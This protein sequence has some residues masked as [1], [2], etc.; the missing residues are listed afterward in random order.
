MTYYDRIRKVAQTKS[1]HNRIKLEKYGRS[2][3]F[4]T[5]DK[6]MIPAP[7]GFDWKPTFD[8]RGLWHGAGR[9]GRDYRRLLETHPPY[10]DKYSALAGA[11]MINASFC[12]G[13]TWD[14]DIDL[15]DLPEKHQLY[16]L[17]HG[18]GGQHHFCHDVGGIGFPLGWGGLLDKV[19]HYKEVYRDDPEKLEFLTGEEDILLGIQSWVRR[20]ADEAARLASLEDDP[21]LRANL[22]EIARINYN[23]VS[24]PPK[25]FHE[26]CQFLVYFLL[27]AVMF[28][29]SGA[30]GAIDAYL[31][32]YFDADIASGLLTEEKATYILASLLVKDNQY[33]EIGGCWPDGSDRTSRL[34]YLV[35]EASHWLKIP[36]AICVR[37]H[38]DIDPGLMELAVRYLFEDKHGSPSFIGDKA[39]NEG[40]VKNGYSMEVARTRAKV[41]CSWGCLPGTEYT[42]NDIVKINF[43]KVF[44][45]AWRDMMDDD[46]VEPSVDRLWEL[47]EYRVNDAVEAIADSID[48]Q[49]RHI[50]R[51]SPE[52]A[53]DFMCHGPIERGV[54]IASGG[55]D[56]YNMCVDG[57]GLAV[58][59]DSFGALRERVEKEHRCTFRELDEILKNN[60]EGH[61][62]LRLLF[63][64]TPRYGSGGSYA[65]ECAVRFIDIFVKAVKKGPTKD[66][67]N[68]IPGLFSWANTLPM[69]RVLGATPNG[70]KAG[71]PINHGANPLPG[72]K[73]SGELTAMALAVS[74]VQPMWGNTAPIQ[75]EID[76]ILGKD[77]GGVEK[78]V[79]FL[80]TYCCDLNGTLV[81]INILDKDTILDAHAHPE[82]HPDLVVRVTGF[83]AYFCNLSQDFRQLVVDR[84][85]RG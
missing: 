78:M 19:R 72:F 10:V 27:Q 81:N 52:M 80:M 70:R 40:F 47:F 45:V 37:V 68:M 14:P 49:M 53:L 56:N 18:I 9:I 54:D 28:N 25:T 6:G 22:E 58:L 13:N 8:E 16:D 31:K 2:G 83:S 57:A 44:E 50:G 76:P 69:G 66:G 29:G 67:F 39:M 4:D 35:L 41:G 84:I 24:D 73:E 71:E 7:D 36:N 77:E 85:I 48:M 79:S 26:C 23:I 38:R 55:V 51:L 20:N 1:E 42:L 30:G 11:F 33:F 63:S 12:R 43:A 82:R 60:W 32:P 65:D 64:R 34:S 21:E 75:L 74:S 15:G 46:T 3:Y 59:A 62:D 17:V 5:D 61:E